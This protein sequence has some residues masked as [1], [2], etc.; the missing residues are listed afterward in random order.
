MRI[1]YGYRIE[2]VCAHDLPLITLL[3][4]H[5]S[6]R[7]DLTTP[8]EMKVS[9]LADPS[10]AIA[11][12]Q[13]LDA[14][15][16]IRR[17][18]VAPPGGIR[19]ESEGI[20]LD[21]G[22]PDSV[23][24]TAREVS[25]ARLPDSAL[26]YLLGSRYCETDKLYDRAW[27]LFGQIQ[28]GWARVRAITDSV[29]NHLSFGY[30]FARDTRTAVEAFEERIGVCR[31]FAHLAVALCRCMN[32]PA[33]YCNGYL[34]DIGVPPNPAPMDFNAWFEVF[35]GGRWYTFD[36]RHNEP[37]IGR[38]VIARGR[39]ATDVAMI[40]SFGNHGLQCFEV[41][42]EEVEEAPIALMPARP[43]ARSAAA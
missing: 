21:S 13:D 27:S 30:H 15:G 10:R 17:R 2:L 43:G 7:H 34:G 41:V 39:D 9:A 8:D 33:R 22:E 5:P 16:N 20:V 29:H 19:L 23:D 11:V 24:P 28:P 42:T 6:R 36:A 32:I 38:I 1:R 37:R 18:M 12:T 40:S 25:P 14:F 26:V 31:D 3:D 35:L 4:V